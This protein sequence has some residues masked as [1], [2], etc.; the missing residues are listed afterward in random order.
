MH[1][2][3][4]QVEIFGDKMKPMVAF[5]GPLIFGIWGLGWTNYICIYHIYRVIKKFCQI[6]GIILPQKYNI[7]INNTYIHVGLS[8]I[9]ILLPKS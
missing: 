8:Y 7:H 3:S 6:V 5:H 1:L 4:E 9:N 2:K